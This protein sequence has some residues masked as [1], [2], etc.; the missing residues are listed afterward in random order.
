MSFQT[1]H[2]ILPFLLFAFFVC[3]FSHESSVRFTVIGI[4]S[5]NKEDVKS[6]SGELMPE[7]SCTMSWMQCSKGNLHLLKHDLL[8]CVWE[9]KKSLF[10]AMQSSVLWV[11]AQCG[12]SLCSGMHSVVWHQIKVSWPH[13]RTYMNRRNLITNVKNVI[14]LLMGTDTKWVHLGKIL[15]SYQESPIPVQNPD[16][17]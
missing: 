17:I 15:T 13:S 9:K 4:C 5:H 6:A 16:S 1:L 2:F 8:I 12:V 11:I 7:T 3:F 14:A 10:Q